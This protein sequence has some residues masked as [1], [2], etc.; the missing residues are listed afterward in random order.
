MIAPDD[1]ALQSYL[2]AHCDPE[3]P[4]LHRLYRRVNTDLLYCRMCSGHLQ[5]RILKMLT[6][7][8]NPRHVLELGTYAG[9]SALC[10]AE[11]LIHPDARVTTIEIDDE[12]EDFIRQAL[13][14][15]PAGGRVNLIIGDSLQLLHTLEPDWDMVYIDANKRHYCDYYNLLIDRLHPGAYIIADNTLWDGKVVDPGP[16]PDPQ[17]RG[18]MQFNDLIATDPRVEKVIIPL[19]DGLTIIRKK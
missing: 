14:E 1:N 16:R 10:I 7:M 18:I 8:I 3:P 19:R 11:G 9:Y 12:M 17:T 4:A 6:R 13:A 2:E 5:G 15:H